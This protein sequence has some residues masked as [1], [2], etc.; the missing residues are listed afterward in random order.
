MSESRSARKKYKKLSEPSLL[1]IDRFLRGYLAGKRILE[2]DHDVGETFS[3][4]TIPDED[5]ALSRK[6]AQSN[7]EAVRLLVMSMDC[8]VERLFL[9]Y[10][11]ISG[12][13]MERCSERLNLSRSSVYRA[14]RRALLMAAE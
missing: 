4:E 1:A 2:L 8:S 6:E 3:S 14:K 13:S 11:Y 12:L 7:M 9:Y 10:H 5:T